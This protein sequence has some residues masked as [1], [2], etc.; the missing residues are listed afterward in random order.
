MAGNPIQS[1]ADAA[2]PKPRIIAQ[3]PALVTDNVD[4]A[5][6]FAAEQLSFYEAI[7]G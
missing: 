5:K 3:V 6:A 1:A 4:A 2:R 7:P